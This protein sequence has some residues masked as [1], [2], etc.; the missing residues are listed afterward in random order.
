MSVA[1]GTVTRVRVGSST[2]N[3]ASDVP[4]WNQLVNAESRAACDTAHDRTV[5]SQVLLDLRTHA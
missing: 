3:A 5:E 1:A 4:W 2:A